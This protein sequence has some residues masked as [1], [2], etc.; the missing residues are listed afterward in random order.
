MTKKAAM[1]PASSTCPHGM[2]APGFYQPGTSAV[3]E[4]RIA[5]KMAHELDAA[6]SSANLHAVPR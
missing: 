5:D 4:I 1:P 3:M 2:P 6:Q